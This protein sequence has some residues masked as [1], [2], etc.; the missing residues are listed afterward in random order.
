MQITKNGHTLK[1]KIKHYI[2]EILSFILIMTLFA[3]ALSYYKSLDLNNKELSIKSVSLIEGKTYT[4]DES[5]PML[6]HFWATWCPTCKL[7][8]Q[9]IEYVSKY[10]N[11][12]S[13]AVNSGSDEDILNYLKEHNLSYKVVNDSHSIYASEFQIA[14]YPTTFIY[15]KNQNLVF[16]EVGY[17]STF[18]LFLRM[19][20]ANF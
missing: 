10:Y 15:D 4:I 9:N 3:N 11:V 6:I 17:T 14:A 19:W 12:L 8:A 20:W 5:K 16:S 7:E 18:G 1:T 13:I 2:K